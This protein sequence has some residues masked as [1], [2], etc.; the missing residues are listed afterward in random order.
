ME[1][2]FIPATGMAMS[3][4]EL[5]VWLKNP[6][7]PIAAGDAIA[8]IETDKVT[9]DIVAE[10]SGTL[11]P[12]LVEAGALVDAGAVVTTVLHED[13]PATTP[14]PEPEPEPEPAPREVSEAP[15]A[16]APAPA[17]EPERD[18]AED[19]APL[20]RATI[21]APLAATAAPPRRPH[22][23]TPRRR[24]LQREAAEAAA[25]AAQHATAPAL[26]DGIPEQAVLPPV[27]VDQV[28]RAVTD[29]WRTVPH[30]AVSREIDVTGLIPYLADVRLT[31]PHVSLTDVLLAVAARAWRSL[32]PDAPTGV[33]LSVA[34]DRRVINVTIADAE[35]ADIAQTAT[36]RRAA[37]ARAR[38]GMLAPRDLAACEVTVSNLGMHGV[39]AFTG[40]IPN[41][42]LAL[43]TIGEA[44]ETFQLVAGQPVA[45]TRV[46]VTANLDHRYLDGI[47]GARLLEGFA[48]ASTLT[49][50]APESHDRKATT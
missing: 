38:R 23:L 18:V 49:L 5:Q 15:P 47:D 13:D 17:P 39:H 3:E 25:S 43:I 2:I 21:D 48:A 42:Q 29:A 33:G 11:G 46:W 8:T 10:T 36:A 14:A 44:R 22:T 40:I 24:R 19:P 32:R 30:F 9:V 16:P 7:D 12:H 41:N 37:V 4:A 50:A 34:T 20:T 31:A 35:G 6:G 1:E 45:R 28:S 26:I 27:P